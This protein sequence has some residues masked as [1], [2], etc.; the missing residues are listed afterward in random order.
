MQK[1]PKGLTTQ[2]SGGR[3]LAH[4]T[5]GTGFSLQSHRSEEL[6]EAKTKFLNKN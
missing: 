2:L 1:V 5:Q 4:H 3:V 6:K